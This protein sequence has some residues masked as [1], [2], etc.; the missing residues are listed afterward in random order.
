MSPAGPYGTTAFT[1]LRILPKKQSQTVFSGHQKREYPFQFLEQSCSALRYLHHLGFK[2]NNMSLYQKTE[3]RTISCTA[4]EGRCCPHAEQVAGVHL[5]LLHSS[6]RQDTSMLLCCSLLRE[7]R[8][9]LL[10]LSNFSTGWK[11]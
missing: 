11:N 2:E 4:L 10:V 7:W 9:V 3:V 5:G 6:S 8:L 1:T